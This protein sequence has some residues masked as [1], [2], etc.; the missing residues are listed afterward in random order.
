MGRSLRK[1][2]CRSRSPSIDDSL[3]V[4]G[5]KTI[6]GVLSGYI[7]PTSAL[8]QQLLETCAKPARLRRSCTSFAHPSAQP[9]LHLI[10][11][12]SRFRQCPSLEITF[13]AASAVVA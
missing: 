5:W 8:S 4:W 6:S 10:S 13:F 2:P 7:W 12:P 9:A 11:N 1:R 3:F